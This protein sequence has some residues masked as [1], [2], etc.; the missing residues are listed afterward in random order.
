MEPYTAVGIIPKAR[1]TGGRHSA[2]YLFPSRVRELHTCQH[3]NTRLVHRWV[4]RRSRIVRRTCALDRRTKLP[5]ISEKSGNLWAV[6][7]LL[8]HRNWRIQHLISGSRSI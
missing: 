5:Q 3:A 7:L 2:Q 4:E 8:R 1:A 6:Q